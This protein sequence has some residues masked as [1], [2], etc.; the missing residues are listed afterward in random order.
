MPISDLTASLNGLLSNAKASGQSV[1]SGNITGTLADAAETHLGETAESWAKQKFVWLATILGI[2]GIMK[3]IPPGTYAWTLNLLGSVIETKLKRKYP[4]FAGVADT[5]ISH[6]GIGIKQGL[7]ENADVKAEPIN[8]KAVRDRLVSFGLGLGTLS[9]TLENPIESSSRT[10]FDALPAELLEHYTALSLAIWDRI[11]YDEPLENRGNKKQGQIHD[12]D[13]M[14]YRLDEAFK[15][16][17]TEKPDWCIHLLQS[18]IDPKEVRANPMRYGK[19]IFVAALSLHEA[20]RWATWMDRVDGAVSVPAVQGLI[21]D[22]VTKENLRNAYATGA[23]F[24]TK[25]GKRVKNLIAILAFSL[26]AML[27]VSLPM[28][29]VGLIGVFGAMDMAWGFWQTFCIAAGIVGAVLLIKDVASSEDDAMYKVIM[30]IP[31]SLGFWLVVG[32]F[33]ANPVM[34]YILCATPSESSAVQM[35]RLELDFWAWHMGVG[36]VLVWI[37]RALLAPMIDR[38][39]DLA[40]ALALGVKATVSAGPIQKLVTALATWLAPQ[41]GAIEFAKANRASHKP[42]NILRGPLTTIT[43]IVSA[44]GAMG[45]LAMVVKTLENG[46]QAGD[47]GLRIFALAVLIGTSAAGFVLD[48]NAKWRDDLDP[49]VM[50]EMK[51]A[52]M[53]SA[54]RML[55]VAIM[56]AVIA[57]GAAMLMP[58]LN[59]HFQAWKQERNENRTTHEADCWLECKNIEDCDC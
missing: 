41:L 27:V 49:K 54:Y 11:R 44:L 47:E 38:T 50:L 16:L 33:M 12:L 17:A 35:N 57:G 53:K 39:L 25:E 43:M 21:G 58:S 46:V 5:L 19:E 31:A 20:S 37:S 26:I 10:V 4:V 36:M 56:V 51:E 14:A 13:G 18:G 40:R 32:V 6:L 9:G 24:A 7:I 23:I 8:L 15:A 30:T 28:T 3:Q 52:T 59:A 22:L 2:V 48:M 45:F 1:L 34:Q 55:P 29:T 42:V